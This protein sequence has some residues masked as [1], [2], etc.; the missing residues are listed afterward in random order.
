MR[1]E[2]N[3]VNNLHLDIGKADAM[4]VE[5]RDLAKWSQTLA[6]LFARTAR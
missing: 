2:I 4:Q 3:A 5:S 1:K 6:D